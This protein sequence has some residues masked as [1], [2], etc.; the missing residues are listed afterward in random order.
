MTG[1]EPQTALTTEPQ[2]L[3]YLLL[4]LSLPFISSIVGIRT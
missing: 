3:P 2:P 4:S 1:F